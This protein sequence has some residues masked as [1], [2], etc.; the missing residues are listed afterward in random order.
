MKVGFRVPSLK[1]RIA[2]R[3]SWKRYA[4]QSLG[5]KVPKGYGWITD[6][7]K[8]LYNRIY[9]RTT[10]GCSVALFLYLSAFGWLCGCIAWVVTSTLNLK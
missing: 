1:K 6:P 5:F 9:Y 10:K 2:A 8:A 4:R 3:T 7:K